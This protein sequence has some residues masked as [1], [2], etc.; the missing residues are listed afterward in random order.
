MREGDRDTRAHEQFERGLKRFVGSRRTS[1]YKRSFPCSL[2]KFS[3]QLHK[4]AV[5]SQDSQAWFTPGDGAA[6]ANFLSYL[7]TTLGGRNYSIAVV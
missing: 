4:I 5:P 1:R 7:F 6:R 3:A 2:V